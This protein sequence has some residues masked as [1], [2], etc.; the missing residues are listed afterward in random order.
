MSDTFIYTPKGYV[1][2]RTVERVNFKSDASHTIIV[3]GEVVDNNHKDFGDHVVSVVPCVT[4][5]EYLTIMEGSDEHPSDEILVEP[6]LAWGLTVLGTLI[7]MTPSSMEG[8]TELHYGL[9]KTGSPRVYTA[10]NI[11][12]WPSDEDWATDTLRRPL[13]K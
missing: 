6:V 12:G 7:P 3:D 4:E 11:G 10:S 9:R 13:R 1:N 5:M 2:L 8:V